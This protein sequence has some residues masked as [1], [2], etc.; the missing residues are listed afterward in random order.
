MKKDFRLSAQTSV[1][2]T[3]KAETNNFP[4]AAVCR[5]KE[6]NGTKR[7]FYMSLNTL[8]ELLGMILQV[9]CILKRDCG[10]E[11][12]LP[13]DDTKKVSVSTFRGKKYVCFSNTG[14]KPSR[15][16]INAEEFKELAKVKNEI[17]D[18]I[19]SVKTSLKKSTGD[20]HA[21][22]NNSLEQNEELKL[23]VFKWCYVCQSTGNTLVES[24]RSYLDMEKCKSEGQRNEPS[25]DL[26]PHSQPPLFMNYS[27][28][29][30]LPAIADIFKQIQV[31]VFKKNIEAL[32]DSE[33][34]AC[35]ENVAYANPL[36]DEGCCMEWLVAMEHYY[37]RIYS[38]LQTELEVTRMFD[39]VIHK[40]GKENV[41]PPSCPK[42]TF[43]EIENWNNIVSKEY[44]ELYQAVDKD[45]HS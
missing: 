2:V 10:Y 41:S 40:C 9:S 25:V 35:N 1:Y 3:S 16:N 30:P 6:E 11:Q 33:C 5:Q 34:Y 36:H 12:T 27:M 17:K 4:Y 32:R 13:L 44:Y 43:Q 15:M 37:L 22:K 45:S 19:K 14:K 28:N 26:L 38:S 39:Q 23:T 31:Y 20:E 42:P 18:F 21:N 29:V 7:F 8:L 24:N